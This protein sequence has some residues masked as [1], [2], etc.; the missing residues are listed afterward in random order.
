MLCYCVILVLIGMW[1]FVNWFILKGFILNVILCW[2]FYVSILMK[3]YFN[4]IW[5]ICE[6]VNKKVCWYIGLVLY[7]VIIWKKN[8]FSFIV[9]C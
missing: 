6:N 3:F 2:W 4:S 7:I 8:I 1:W 5:N 9:K